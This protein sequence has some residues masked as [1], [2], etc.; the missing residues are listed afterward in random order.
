MKPEEMGI[1]EIVSQCAFGSERRLAEH[2][3]KHVIEGRDERWHRVLDDTL[4]SAAR[5][6]WKCDGWYGP[7]CRRLAAEYQR[8][9]A[10]ALLK[11]C[12][13]GSWHQHVVEFEVQIRGQREYEELATAQVIEAWP[14]E[15]RLWIVAG[16]NVSDERLGAYRLR[17]G[18]RP[19][20]RLTA[21]GFARAARQ[22]SLERRLLYPGR[23]LALH[24]TEN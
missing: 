14:V 7:Q 21:K 8:L 20:P 10:D 17:T 1:V 12:V 2:V 19:W 4:I 3:C 16:A 18:Y 24:D 11:A 15:D 22:R 13:G 23:P 9:L 6:E 5:D